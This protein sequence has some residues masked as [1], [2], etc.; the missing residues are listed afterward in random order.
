M[1][2]PTDS[3]I[4]HKFKSDAVKRRKQLKRMK[5]TRNVS[6]RKKTRIVPHVKLGKYIVYVRD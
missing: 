4:W 1:V 6:M 3:K 2:R 5:S